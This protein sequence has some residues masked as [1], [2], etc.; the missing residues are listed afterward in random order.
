MK[1]NHWEI[2]TEPLQTGQ[3]STQEGHFPKA[4]QN[5][6]HGVK[7]TMNPDKVLKTRDITF[8]TKILIVKAMVFPVVMY[9]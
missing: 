4:I 9:R 3:L 6:L 1:G 5:T 7:A 8:P 2:H